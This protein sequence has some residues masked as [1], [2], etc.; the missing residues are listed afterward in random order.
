MGPPAES[1][2]RPP[3]R[4][5]SPGTCLAPGQHVPLVLTLG[6]AFVLALSAQTPIDPFAFFR[7]SVAVSADDRRQLD[8]G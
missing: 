5:D 2:T 1:L 4:T 7:P 3:V 6:L 8:R